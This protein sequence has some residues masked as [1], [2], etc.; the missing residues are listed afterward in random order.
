MQMQRSKKEQ[1]SLNIYWAVAWIPDFWKF[2][3]LRKARKK[4]CTR[5]KQARHGK[6]ESPIAPYVQS[7]ITAMQDVSGNLRKWMLTMSQH[8]A[9]AGQP[10][11]KTVRCFA[12]CTTGQKETNNHRHPLSAGSG[13]GT[14][15]RV[16]PRSG[17]R[18]HPLSRR[19]AGQSALSGRRS[20]PAACPRSR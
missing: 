2:V 10:I 14:L 4:Q 13:Q 8:G 16:R 1:V 17:Q 9:R 5:D 19:Q 12:R 7:E 11:S 6:V 18:L 3:F 20:A 15:R